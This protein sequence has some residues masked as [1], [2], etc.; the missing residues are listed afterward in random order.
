MMMM[1]MM[2]M[3]TMNDDD[4]DDDDD[5]EEEEDDDDDGGLEGW[6]PLVTPPT[7]GGIPT[8]EWRAY[9]VSNQSSTQKVFPHIAG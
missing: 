2:M 4:D 9:T 1:M 5:E 8:M 7:L 6:C 3:M